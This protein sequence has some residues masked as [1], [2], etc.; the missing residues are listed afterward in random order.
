MVGKEIR[1]GNK[2]I[3][4]FIGSY[5]LERRPLPTDINLWVFHKSWDWIMILADKIRSNGFN[6]VL[7]NNLVN[8]YD[9]ATFDETT[10]TIE[11]IYMCLN[12]DLPLIENLYKGIIEFI[13]WYYKK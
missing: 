3:K 12:P 6:I 2:L 9:A 5:Y 8:I 1:K 13:K 11:P 10:E 4:K 7:D